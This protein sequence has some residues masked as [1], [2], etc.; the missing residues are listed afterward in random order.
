MNHLI[1]GPVKGFDMRVKLEL[2]TDGYTK[3][4]TV[5]DYVESSPE[6]FGRIKLGVDGTMPE[7]LVP[8]PN[9]IESDIKLLKLF[10]NSLNLS[11][12]H[13]KSELMTCFV[14]KISFEMTE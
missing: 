13:K 1:A 3:I 12:I 9:P 2:T 14:H 4:L 5:S 6:Q 7:A 8:A 11:F 10:F